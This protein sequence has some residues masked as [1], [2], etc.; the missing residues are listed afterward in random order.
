MTSVN[1][2]G[3]TV[4]VTNLTCPNWQSWF[5]AFMYCNPVASSVLGLMY[6]S[7]M[8]LVLPVT[9]TENGGG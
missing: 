2:G 5:R 9:V 3:R 8:D 4:Q 6:G 1:N 7:N